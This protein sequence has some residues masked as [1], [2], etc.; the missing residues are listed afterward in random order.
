MRTLQLRVYD[1]FINEAKTVITHTQRNSLRKL[2]DFKF[3]RNPRHN[4]GPK[5]LAMVEQMVSER[6]M[7][8]LD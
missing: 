4:W 8:I 3:K 7:E 1:D 6:A 2:L 5:R